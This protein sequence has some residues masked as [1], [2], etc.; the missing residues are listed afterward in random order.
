MPTGNVRDTTGAGANRWLHMQKTSQREWVNRMANS[1]Y[2]DYET[3]SYSN[4][5]LVELLEE[6]VA[7][8]LGKEKALFFHKGSICCLAALMA[9]AEKRDNKQVILHPKSHIHMDETNSYQTVG[10]LKGN[11]I[12]DDLPFDFNMVQQVENK[13]S[14]LTVEL[15]L[16]RV[17]FQLTPWDELEKMHAW[18]KEND[19]HFHMDGARLWE[20]AHYYGKSVADI[21]SLFDSVY[22]S[23]YKGLAGIGGAVLAG[24][25][26]FIEDC[27]TWRAR[28][29]GLH[30]TLFPML[31]TGL[32]GL[33]NE[34]PK[35][36]GYA[37]RALAIS[38]ELKQNSRIRIDKPVHVNAFQI[39]VRG[40]IETINAKRSELIRERGYWPVRCFRATSDPEWQFVEFEVGYGSEEI[41]N[42]EVVEFFSL[43]LP[44]LPE[45]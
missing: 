6:R 12:G 25:A 44:E 35:I 27:K 9:A 34:L 40:D 11:L 16:R 7:S 39:L 22:V 15:P 43:L 17:G 2:I 13:A 23:L 32:D 26:D 10:S 24:D 1:K 4:G 45:S 38:K 37:E 3:D 30:W 21:A 18:C 41:T 31:V 19:V 20:S 36:S 8:L 33:D 5:P 14:V 28:L 29:G 42:D